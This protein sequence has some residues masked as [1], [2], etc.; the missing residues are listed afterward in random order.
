M[1]TNDA[2]PVNRYVN[3]PVT[4]SQVLAA[5]EKGMAQSLAYDLFNVNLIEGDPREALLRDVLTTMIFGAADG[6]Q[7]IEMLTQRLAHRP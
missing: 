5:M 4:S 1:S 6:P 2:L 3:V 7:A